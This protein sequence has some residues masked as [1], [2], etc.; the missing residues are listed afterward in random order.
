[1]LLPC[2]KT[3]IAKA[4][5]EG[6][7][8]LQVWLARPVA[9]LPPVC[10]LVI[11]VMVILTHIL[12]SAIRLPSS[13][14]GLTALL[15]IP[16]VCLNGPSGVAVRGHALVAAARIAWPHAVLPITMLRP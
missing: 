2:Y 8:H 3:G 11:A 15:R 16:K 4:R 13:S 6:L 10:L 7:L 14:I 12:C 1:M 9:A 5:F